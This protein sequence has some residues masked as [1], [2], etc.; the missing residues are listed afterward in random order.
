MWFW[1][2]LG[3]AFVAF[4]AVLVT[5]YICYYRIFMSHRHRKKADSL[6]DEVTSKFE[7]YAD[8][9]EEFRVRVE[10]LDYREVEIRSREGLKLCGRYYEYEQGAPIEVMMHGYRGSREKDMDAG[11]IRA[12]ACGHSALCVDHRACGESE[13]Q[14]ITFGVHESRDCALWVNFVIENIDRNAKIILSGVS[15][16]AA[17]VLTAAG[18]ALPPNVVGVVADCGYTSAK[19]II[20]NTMRDMKLPPRLLYP[21]AV[22]GGKLFGG[23]NIDET[24]PIEMMGR[25]SLPVIFLHGSADEFV[26]YDMSVRNFNACVSEKKQLITVDGAPH[27]IAFLVDEEGYV[28]AV[29]EFFEGLC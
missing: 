27:G 17:T 18:R 8:R 25:C 19:E 10:A 2:I 3:I 16:G 22:L 21:F 20:M 29:K 28:K 4:G 7:P 1:I 14:V 13:G 24:S 12:F 5:S 15:M 11:V 26:P 23:F 6:Q 9:L